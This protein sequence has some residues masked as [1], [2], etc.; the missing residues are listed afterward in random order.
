MRQRF[1]LLDGIRGICVA[2]MVVYHTLFD[3]VMLSGAEIPDAALFVFNLIRDIG[4]SVFILIS[5]MCFSLGEHRLRRFLILLFAGA[6]ITGA[7]YLFA[8]EATVICGILS[9]MCLS[10]GAAALLERALKKIPAVPGLIISFLLFIIMFRVNYGYLGTYSKMLFI[11]PSFLY[12]NYFTAVLGFPFNGF[13]SGD[14]Y[15]FVPWIF[16]YLT[17]YFLWRIISHRENLQRLLRLKIP[18]F[19]FLGKYSLIIYLAHQPV[20]YAL[21][22]LIVPNIT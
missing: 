8:R 9:F 5:G 21:C 12:R 17:G 20:I 16:V 14:Y 4:A 18:F 7:T 2:G 19:G 3:I 11:M 15:G 22:W 13:T 6:A 1:Y 10:G